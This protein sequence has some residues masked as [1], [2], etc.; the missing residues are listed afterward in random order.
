MAE[1]MGR[2]FPIFR[3][4][5]VRRLEGVETAAQHIGDAVEQ[6]VA[7]GAE[8]ALEAV[9]LAGDAGEGEGAAGA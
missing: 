6:D 9:A 7:Y 3:G 8:F 4:R 1:A 5:A 2:P